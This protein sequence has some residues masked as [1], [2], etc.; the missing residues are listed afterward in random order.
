MCRLVTLLLLPTVRNVRATALQIQ[1]LMFGSHFGKKCSVVVVQLAKETHAA[2]QQGSPNRKSVGPRFGDG[3][4]QILCS[5]K[6]VGA[7]MRAGY[8][9]AG[10]ERTRMNYCKSQAFG[11]TNL[12]ELPPLPYFAL[13]SS[14]R[15]RI[16][17]S[18]RTRR[19]AL[20][21]A[22]AR[23]NSRRRVGIFQRH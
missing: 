6:F 4:L 8:A 16:F 13:F 3:D 17:V 23:G 21:E 19:I 14:C 7:V 5:R 20:R 22:L 11:N 15:L 10:Y 1:K 12:D 18:R 2:E 9:P